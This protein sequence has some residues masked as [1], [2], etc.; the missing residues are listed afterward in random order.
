M[1]GEYETDCW[2]SPTAVPENN[3]RYLEFGDTRSQMVIYELDEY[4]QHK[5]PPRV[6]RNRV[7]F[8]NDQ[9]CSERLPV[10][11]TLEMRQ[12]ETHRIG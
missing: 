7:R 12:G 11:G 9:A 6:T 2:S 8:V 5:H 4:V 1:K 10:A 3:Y